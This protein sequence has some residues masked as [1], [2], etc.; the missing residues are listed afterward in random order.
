[1][2]KLQL[3]KADPI[4]YDFMRSLRNDPRVRAGF[5]S[6]DEISPESN[7]AHMADFGHLYRVCLC[8]GEAAGYVRSKDG[9]ISVVT[10]PNFQRRGI[11]RF[12][13]DGIMDEFPSS[14]ALVKIDNLSSLKLFESCGFE[15]QFYLLKRPGHD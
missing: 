8:D 6:Q 9:D 14:H 4:Y 11:G 5:I 10:H 3:V 1:M 7:A 12:M 2:S 13:I 15:K